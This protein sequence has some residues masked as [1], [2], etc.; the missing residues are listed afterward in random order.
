MINLSQSIILVEKD[1]IK[2]IHIN[3]IDI[4]EVGA[5]TIGLCNIPKKWTLPFFVI[6]TKL[7]ADCKR[8]PTATEEIIKSYVDNINIALSRL[9]I[10]DSVILRSSAI[11]EGMQERGKFESLEATTINL[12]E[13]LKTLI[14]NLIPIEN[15]GMAIIVQQ[16]SDTVIT[17]HMSNE[18]RF[19][20]DSRDWKVEYYL[21]KSE[22]E[23]DTIAIREWREKLNLNGISE[24]KLIKTKPLSKELKKVAYFWYH[25]SKDNSCRYHLEFVCDNNNIFIVQSDKDVINKNAIK[26]KTVSTKVNSANITLRFKVLKKYSFEETPYSK[27]NN[28]REYNKLN[29]PTVP[30]YYL[31]DIDTLE[32]LKNKTITEDLKTDLEQLLK[33]QSIIIRCDNLSSSQKERQMLPRSTELQNYEAV[34]LWLNENL[35]SIEKNFILIIHNYIPSVASAFAYAE[36][37]NRIV[38]IQSLWGVPEGLYYNYHD[39]IIVNLSNNE[40]DKITEDDVTLIIRNRFKDKFVYPMSDGRWSVETIAAPFDWNCSIDDK[41]SIFQIA[42]SSQKIADSTGKKVSVMWF[43]DIDENYY[44]TKN[45]PWYHEEV[46]L[47]SYTSDN[48][49]RKYFSDEEITITSRAELEEALQSN[50]S[51][52]IKCIRLKPTNEEDL[53]NKKFLKEVGDLA[54]EKNIIILLEGTQLTHSYYQLKE[55]GANVVCSE[56]KELLYTDILEFN[57]LVRDR[58]PEK[59]ISNGENIKY[60]YVA[61]IFYNSL[62]LEKLL[63]ETFEVYDSSNLDDLISEIADVQEVCNTIIDI[64]KKSPIKRINLS[65][66]YKEDLINEVKLLCSV[67]IDNETVFNSYKI[68]KGVLTLKIEREKTYYKFEINLYNYAPDVS[69]FYYDEQTFIPEISD[70]KMAMVKKASQALKHTDTTKILSCVNEISLIVSKICKVLNMPKKT[71]DERQEKKAQKNGGFKRGYVLLQT[72]LK[73]TIINKGLNF[74]I[75]NVFETEDDIDIPNQISVSEKKCNKYS[76]YL[77]DNQNKTKRF[78]MRFSVPVTTNEWKINFEN[79]K[80]NYFIPG[81]RN[82]IFH[83]TKKRS[84]NL[85]LNIKKNDYIV[86]TQLSLF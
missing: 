28:V 49:K 4:S 1:S 66:H 70:L 25:L 31:N 30:L 71:I 45:L 54:K 58:I 36:P 78:L 39:T 63:E 74:E 5:K 18:R 62:L 72:S 60:G 69:E 50:N 14:D 48:Y 22:F 77:C 6:S 34:E 86:N 81:C 21:N 43:V 65:D 79:N 23:Q 41:A 76:D 47:S 64:S 33:I 7:F 75:D 15:E 80:I 51:D 19:S 37:N 68:E 61:G 57:K 12:T 67:R 46:D 44:K 83:I 17:G 52:T 3:N 59:I 9:N 32:N 2:D 20:K 13:K 8:N 26:P 55:T 84:G 56:N 10:S 35:S 85:F 82:L 16:L 27:L 73:D 24:S 40:L 11:N 42:K 29:L 38:K 53:R